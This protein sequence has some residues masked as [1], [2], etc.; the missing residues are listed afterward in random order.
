[1]IETPT[2]NARLRE[3][4]GTRYSRRDRSQ[5]RLPAVIYGH[6]SKP[7]HVTVDES[8]ALMHL[9]DGA[10]VV[11]LTVEGGES[12]TCLVKDL[13]FGYL[14][15]NVIHIDFARVD[16][17][18]EV[19]VKVHLHFVGTPKEAGKPGSIV[20]HDIMEL[21]VICKVIAIPEEIR[22]DLSKME[23]MRLDV[24]D[25]TLPE[26]VRSAVPLDAPVVRIELVKEEEE[27]GEAAAVEATATTEPEVL[28][29]TAKKAREAAASE[30]KDE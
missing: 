15:D 23:G 6:G 9:H 30:K 22:V 18:E 10:H 17:D 2:I 27:L 14:G 29:E 20:T 4:M 13:Q 19:E 8:E 3:R 5:G 21:E 12:A 24:R 25:I 7:M 28:T 16:L 1:M 11:N 26:G